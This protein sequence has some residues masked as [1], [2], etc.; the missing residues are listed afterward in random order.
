MDW[1]IVI[2]KSFH[3]VHDKANENGTAI[4]LNIN[5]D[6]ILLSNYRRNLSPETLLWLNLAYVK[7]LIVWWV[8][9]MVLSK[10]NLIMLLGQVIS[11]NI[12]NPLHFILL[13]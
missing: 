7:T 1:N 3:Y 10:Q 2:E 9:L 8:S 5:P 13:E 4:T 11:K 6:N 12:V